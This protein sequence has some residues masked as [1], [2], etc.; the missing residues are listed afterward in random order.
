VL[1]RNN[2]S[3]AS[4]EAA[5]DEDEQNVHEAVKKLPYYISCLSAL[6]LAFI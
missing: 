5:W 1:H 4:K 6:V 2:A 3:E